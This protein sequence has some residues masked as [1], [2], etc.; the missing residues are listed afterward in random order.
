MMAMVSNFRSSILLNCHDNLDVCKTI[1]PL[2]EKTNNLGFRPD[3]KLTGLYSH[4]ISLVA[5][6]FGFRKK[7]NCTI[8]IAKT[9][10]LMSCAA[11]AQMICAFVFAYA[12]CWFSDAA[13]QLKTAMVRHT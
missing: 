10:A 5:L 9:K 6:N 1:E 2:H 11:A 3:P 4:R 13:A 12:D 8:R 7:R